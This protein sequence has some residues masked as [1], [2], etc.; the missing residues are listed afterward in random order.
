ML[1]LSKCARI[2][3]DVYA[4]DPFYCLVHCTQYNYNNLIDN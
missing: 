4:I 3:S 1:I 2:D